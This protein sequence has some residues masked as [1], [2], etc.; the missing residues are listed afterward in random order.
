MDPPARDIKNYEHVEQTM[1]S[2]NGF[3]QRL[4]PIIAC[5]DFFQ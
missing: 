5:Q 1:I 3:F 4:I 2:P